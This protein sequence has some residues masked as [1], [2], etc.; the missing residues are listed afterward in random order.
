[1]RPLLERWRGLLALLLAA[2][3]G[4]LLLIHLGWA[5]PMLALG[6]RIAEVR[7][8]ELALRMEALQRPELEARL[9]ELASIEA[10][11][12]GFLAESDRDLAAAALVQRLE[13]EV[14]RAASHPQSCEIVTRAPLDAHGTEPFTRVTVQVRLRCDPAVLAA[15]LHGLEGGRPQL[16]IERFTLTS[17][18]A[19]LGVGH[20]VTEARADVGFDLYGYLRPP[21]SMAAGGGRDG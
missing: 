18:A 3:F 20:A 11:D 16:F 6:E 5:G 13:A 8:E 15:V 7:D 19:F 21:A 4:Y 10:A 17:L 2:L 14:R 12:P 9:A 1:M